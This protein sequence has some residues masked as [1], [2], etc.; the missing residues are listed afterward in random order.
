MTDPAKLQANLHKAN[1]VRQRRAQAYR[2][3]ASGSAELVEVIDLEEVGN[4]PVAKLV[5]WLP[6]FG[7]KK[8]VP[9]VLKAA[10]IGE[11]TTVTGLKPEQ[12]AK[13]LEVI[14]NHLPKGTNT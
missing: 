14:P 3:V 12:R 6:G 9:A 11:R 4:M 2:R 7:E 13:L 5:Q 1:A 10:G 8:K